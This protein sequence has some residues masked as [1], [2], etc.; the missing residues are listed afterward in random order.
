MT[1]AARAQAAIEILDTW[2]A[3]QDGMDRILAAWGRRN[4]FAG[5]GDRR[6]IGDLVYD[7]LRQRRSAAWVAGGSED[8]GRAL[9]HGVITIAGADPD[10][11]FTGGRYAPS[12]LSDAERMVGRALSHAPR[13][14]RLD[15][16]DWL[17][18]ALSGYEDAVLQ[19]MQTRAPLFLRVN[20]LKSTPESVIEALSTEDILTKPC[21]LSPTALHVVQGARAVPVSQ[22]WRDG[23]IDV[24]DG[25]SQCIAD[26]VAAAPG[27]IVLDLCAGGGG[28]ALAIAAR[29]GNR[30][31]VLAHDVDPRR[32]AD[33]PVRAK[34][35]GARIRLTGCAELAELTGRMDWVVVD[36]PCSGSGTWR[37]NPDAKWRL[38]SDELERLNHLQVKLL[39]QAAVLCAPDGRILYATCS[40]L[41]A[42]NEAILDAWL[43]RN[44]QWHLLTRRSLVFEHGADGMFGA[45]LGRR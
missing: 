39:D 23:H 37:R 14:V 27:Q 41:D 7:A 24:Q 9:I 16:P 43:S 18:S 11:I 22:P 13:A 29:S 5:S 21:P 25:A 6:A 19:A 42:E 40:I 44:D 36:A 8:D 17:E 28:K 34:R 4:R 33:L 10:A 38:T 31:K 15:Y 30:A 2:S 12:P 45:L 35:A 20:L 3:G 26:L 32:M 1:P